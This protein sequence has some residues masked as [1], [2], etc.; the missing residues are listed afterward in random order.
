MSGLSPPNFVC[1]WLGSDAIQQACASKLPSFSF[2]ADQ[3]VIERILDEGDSWAMSKTPGFVQRPL[4][5]HW[6]YHQA[7]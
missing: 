6:N 3:Q 7:A 5:E 2:L 1:G 4:P